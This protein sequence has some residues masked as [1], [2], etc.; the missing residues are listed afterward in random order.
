MS[1]SMFIAALFK[2]VKWQKQLEWP[3]IDEWINKMWYISIQ[4]NITQPIKRN[5]V[6]ASYFVDINKLILKFI[7]KRQ[8]T[9][10]SQHN[11]EEEKQSQ[12]TNTTG[13]QILLQNYNNQDSVVLEEKKRST[14]RIESPEIDLHKYSPLL[15]D[16]VNSVEK[17]QPFNKRCQNN[18]TST[19]K[20]KIKEIQIQTL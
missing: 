14:D 2:I 3:P 15:F 1:T 11:I 16:K 4:Q 18:W 9:Q 6:P 5:D 13:L 19:Y 7:C 8:K 20:K 12:R 17:G 10:K